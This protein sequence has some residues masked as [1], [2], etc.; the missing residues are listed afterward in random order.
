MRGIQCGKHR[1]YSKD[2]HGFVEADRHL[3]KRLYQRVP[4]VSLEVL[5]GSICIAEVTDLMM[6]RRWVREGFQR[7]C[8]S[9]RG[10]HLGSEKG[11][12]VERTRCV[13]AGRNCKVV[14]VISKECRD[15]CEQWTSSGRQGQWQGLDHGKPRLVFKGNWTSFYGRNNKLRTVCV[16]QLC[17]TL[18]DCTDC[19]LP[20]SS[21]QGTL[22]TRI[23][24]LVSMP[25]CRG[26]SWP[27]DQT[28]VSCTD[29]LGSLPQ[30]L[31]KLE[32]K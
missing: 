13:N 15:A 16:L 19:S 24:K 23:L 8:L 26:S 4:N 30:V 14:N 28:P 1:L 7:W 9:C 6:V 22:Q 21:V 29:R 2:A 27:K 18:C 17:L 20:G 11:L 10:V 32:T 5:H 3:S 25:S 12:L 31:P